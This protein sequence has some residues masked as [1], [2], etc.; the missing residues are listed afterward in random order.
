MDWLV[1]RITVLGFEIQAWILLIAFIFAL[2]I[3]YI[4]AMEPFRGSNF[5]KSEIDSHRSISALGQK[6]PNFKNRK[7]STERTADGSERSS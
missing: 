1:G 3:F 4:I 6:N 5:Q 7:K 2:W